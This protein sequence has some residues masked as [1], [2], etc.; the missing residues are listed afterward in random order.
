MPATNSINSR[1]L[2]LKQVSCSKFITPP[3]LRCTS[4]YRLVRDRY[5]T[6]YYSAY[7]VLG[8]YLQFPL[9]RQFAV[10]GYY[11][12]FPILDISGERHYL[13]ILAFLLK[14]SITRRFNYSTFQRSLF[15]KFLAVKQDQDQVEDDVSRRRG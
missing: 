4:L 10:I 13:A 5:S 12:T 6:F 8:C 7:P 14:H 11:T 3:S 9:R 1:G 2:L 15:Q